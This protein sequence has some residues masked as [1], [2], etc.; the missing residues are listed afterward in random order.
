MTPFVQG[1]LLG[2]RVWAS[3]RSRCAACQARIAFRVDSDFAW[4]IDEGPTSPLV[5]EPSIDW[6]A[7]RAPTIVNDY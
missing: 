2:K 6:A 7:F 3:V 1:R 5:F 4:R